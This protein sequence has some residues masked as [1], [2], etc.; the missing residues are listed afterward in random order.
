MCRISRCKPRKATA[1]PCPRRCEV[2]DRIVDYVLYNRYPESAGDRRR[3]RE[4]LAFIAAGMHTGEPLGEA[5]ETPEPEASHAQLEQMLR[6]FVQAGPSTEKGVLD[7]IR[8]L[9]ELL[10]DSGLLL[11]REGKR[12]GFYH[13][14]FQEFL[15]AERLAVLAA[16][17]GAE[18]WYSLFLRRAP[19]AEWRY[20]LDFL[21]GAYLFRHAS[22]QAGIRL[23]VRLIESLR[24]DALAADANLAW[25]LADCLEIALLKS[26]VLPADK[27]ERFGQNC[28]SAIEQ[29]IPL[30]PR[31]ALG[32]TLGR[33][34]DPRI[35]HPRDRAGYVKIPPGRYPFQDD[36][37]RIEEPYWLSR[38][39]VTNSQFLQFIQDGGYQTKELWSPD[40]WKWLE[41][42]QVSEPRYFRDRR[43][44]APNQP[45][46][47]VSWWEAEAFCRWSGGRL[48]SE[49]EWEAA[50][51]GSEAR[52][53]PWD[54]PWEDGICNTHEAGLG[55]TSP[56]GSFRAPGR[57]ISSW[58]IW[59]VMCGNGFLAYACCAA[60]PRSSNR[61]APAP[62]F[63]TSSTSVPA[64]AMSASG[65]GYCFPSARTDLLPL[66]CF[67]LLPLSP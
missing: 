32:L 47:G 37:I 12:A 30:Q 17:Q 38:Y 52:E 8:R 5:R 56:V 66:R 1:R 46:V 15:A 16:E 61:G 54:G 65:S 58:R 36:W 18:S 51:R 33:I 67:T 41:E 14:S 39:P 9:D 29:E 2:Y 23:L 53:Y 50:A 24:T 31:Q 48:P 19:A 63:A 57:W 7:V 26:C 11:P 27:L 43:H 60:V 10:S 28:L 25:T 6:A 44:D 45:V 40:G 59:P 42:A 62:R 3:V 22:T 49:R 20:T 55:T 35:L 4:R 64:S 34:G 13:F 21:F